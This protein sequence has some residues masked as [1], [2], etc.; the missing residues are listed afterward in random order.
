[1]GETQNL[2]NSSLNLDQFPLEES[3]MIPNG[4]ADQDHH[5]DEVESGDEEMS[6]GEILLQRYSESDPFQ[7]VSHGNDENNSHEYMSEAELA[8]IDE[9]DTDDL[10]ERIETRQRREREQQ[11]TSDQNA[12]DLVDRILIRETNIRSIPTASDPSVSIEELLDY[13]SNENA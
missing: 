1:M 2:I 10:L 3:I 6:T 5:S 9:L 11:A 4:Y 7:S 13:P 8:E 12:D